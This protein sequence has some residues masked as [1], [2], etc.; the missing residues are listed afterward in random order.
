M[1]HFDRA[2]RHIAGPFWRSIC[3]RQV[4]LLGWS[5]ILKASCD[6]MPYLDKGK[7]HN[8]CPSYCC[9]KVAA[10]VSRCSTEY[11]G[12]QLHYP[13]SRHAM[14]GTAHSCLTVSNL[15]WKPAATG[16]LCTEAASRASCLSGCCNLTP[17]PA[18]ATTWLHPACRQQWGRVQHLP[19][20]TALLGSQAAET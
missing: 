12:Q 20:L 16:Q 17:Q 2:A 18:C 6:I 7:R 14:L 11:N 3:S 19:C 9:R 13:A 15:Q 1:L 8:Q 4:R 10:G 5:N